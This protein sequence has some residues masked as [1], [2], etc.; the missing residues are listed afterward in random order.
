MIFILFSIS[1]DRFEEQTE[2]FEYHAHETRS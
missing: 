2:T 1:Y